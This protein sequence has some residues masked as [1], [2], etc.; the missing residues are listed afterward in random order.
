M[1]LALFVG[2]GSLILVAFFVAYI[3][4]SSPDA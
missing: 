4:R 1:T 2:V 3:V